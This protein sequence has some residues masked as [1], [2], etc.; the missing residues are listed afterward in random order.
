MAENNKH[1]ACR[2]YETPQSY[3]RKRDSRLVRTYEGEHKNTVML[4]WPQSGIN[5]ATLAVIVRLGLDISS[6]PSKGPGQVTGRHQSHEHCS[7][8]LYHTVGFGSRFIHRL[9]LVNKT[10]FI[11][12][13][14]GSTAHWFQSLLLTSLF[15]SQSCEL[16]PRETARQR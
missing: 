5:L 9:T 13:A 6:D 4:T 3:P 8:S 14:F 11:V 1:L 15:L 12:L 7:V 16:S 2:F 10:R